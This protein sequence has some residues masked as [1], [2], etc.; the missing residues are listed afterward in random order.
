[1]CFHNFLATQGY[2]SKTSPKLHQ[3][4][5]KKEKY[6]FIIELIVIIPPRPLKGARGNLVGR[7]APH[8]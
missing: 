1:M 3:R 4:I 7:P 2:C 5:K 6:F 8:T